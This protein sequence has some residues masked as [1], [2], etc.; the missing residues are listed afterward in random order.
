MTNSP[1]HICLQ[2]YKSLAAPIAQARGLVCFDSVVTEFTL[3]N[4]DF[5]LI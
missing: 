3:N 1:D 5:P 4:S 2:K